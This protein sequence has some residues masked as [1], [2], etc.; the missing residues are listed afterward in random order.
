LC[1]GVD[2]GQTVPAEGGGEGCRHES[3]FIASGL[4]LRVNTR[5]FHEQIIALSLPPVDLPGK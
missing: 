5:T 3:K 1:V 2:M 4:T